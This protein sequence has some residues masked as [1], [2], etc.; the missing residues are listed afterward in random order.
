M[1]L[2]RVLFWI[3]FLVGIIV[4]GYFLYI[5]FYRIQ[6]GHLQR[7]L[8]MSCFL[9][10]MPRYKKEKELKVNLQEEI[11]KAEQLFSAFSSLESGNFW[12]RFF[13]G[14]A[15]ISLEMASQRGEEEI[16]I[17][18]AGP[19]S[20]ETQ[21]EKTI[22]GV[23]PEA[24]VKK[25][26]EDYNIFSAQNQVAIS[27][28]KLTKESF[29][30]INTYKN[31]EAD[32]LGPI[33]TA[34]SKVSA[35]QGAAVQIVITPESEG[36]QKMG[37]KII[38]ALKQGK[39]LSEALSLVQGGFFKLVR[40]FPKAFT[41]KQTEKKKEPFSEPQITD[42]KTIEAI[43]Q[44]IA[45]VAFSANIRLV[46]TAPNLS[47]AEA[48]LHH[49]EGSFSQF[50]S[51]Q[52][53]SLKAQ[54]Q[55][56]RRLK[57]AIY[58]FIFRNFTS[59]DSLVLNTEELASLFHLP[60]A[61]LEVPK[62]KQIKS[63]ETPIP[64]TLPKKG[65]VLLGEAVFRGQKE[66][67]FLASSE[68]RRRHLYVIGQTGT[69]KTSLFAEMIRQD[70][71]AGRGVGVI[72]PHGDLI[73]KT[74]AN[75]PK[76]RFEDIILFE[77]FDLSRPLGLNMLEWQTPQQKDFAVQEMIAIFQKL[78]PPEIIG[79]MFEH[80]MRNAML[81]LMADQ[82]HPGT[83]V[84]IPRIFTDDNFMQQRLEKVE[85]PLV[86]N[87]W[88]KEWRQT[89]G[90]TRSDMLGYVVSK[91]GRFVENEMMRNIIG[92]SHSS[93]DLG[94]VMDG[95][96]IFLANLS[97][98]KTGEVNSSL[99]GLILVS[100]IQMAAMRRADIPE[101]NRRDFYLY[102]DEFQNFTTENIATILSEARKYRLNLIIAH[103]FIKQLEE[104]I[105][106]AVFGNV[107]SI[108]S[109]R[110]S[111]KDAEIIEKQLEPEFSSYD[112]INLDNFQAAVRLMIQ[113][114]PTP[115]FKMQTI[116][117]QPGNPYQVETLKEIA[118]LKYGRA[119]E[120][121]EQEILQR[122]KLHV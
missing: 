10:R 75:I 33:L 122:S 99:L 21:I 18:L 11:G 102:I 49:V 67:V 94:K 82:E 115:A 62:L 106:E 43:Q 64:E 50:S 66:K 16:G 112:L 76:E 54:R 61:S 59:R 69:G 52:F 26:E 40:Q 95:E 7:A 117:P 87:F 107:G 74:L 47:E 57:K 2:L 51:A 29:L 42:E 120:I 31:L 100:K 41:Q 8:G 44:K 96:K 108:I 48:I 98:G 72:D 101:E 14:P 35:Q 116:K 109:F 32:S 30:P 12:Q 6:R 90:Q 81:A 71:E 105:R 45:K 119:K 38:E 83:L 20:I 111:P 86:R 97:K 121:V 77:P 58:N 24:E 70:I 19:K 89:T 110:I 37:S 118:R 53:N 103:Q 9:I 104:K 63:R 17:F 60:S 34:L 84:E 39:S 56:G 25:L 46:A 3:F 22:H 55:K 36:W 93:F 5:V 114:Q 1:T 27:L 68:D 15:R 80:Y 28:L 92:Q 4:A 13:L 79:P 23:Y 65:E 88:L 78:F 85:D 91:I 73:E 113:G